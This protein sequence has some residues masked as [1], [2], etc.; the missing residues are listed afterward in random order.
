MQASYRYLER[1]RAIRPASIPSSDIYGN[2]GGY[3][4]GDGSPLLF[5]VPNP[6]PGIYTVSVKARPNASLYP[7]AG[8][9][10]RVQEVLVPE[11]NFSGSQNTNGISNAASG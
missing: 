9:T 5:T 8:Y 10:L 6:L 4:S 2:E 7:D 1:R 3:T 11:L